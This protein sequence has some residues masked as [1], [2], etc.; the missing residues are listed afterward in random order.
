MAAHLSRLLV[1][2]SLRPVALRA[3]SRCFSTDTAEQTFYQ[4]FDVEREPRPTAEAPELPPFIHHEYKA[5]QQGDGF[6]IRLYMAGVRKESVKIW[7]Q[8][9]ELIAEGKRDK[10][11]EDEDDTGGLIKYRMLCPPVQAFDLDSIK[12]DL[13]N[14]ILKV[15][16]PKRD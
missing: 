2:S 12:A 10:E 14:G 1:S 6:H 4:M 7:V 15:F 3:G 8:H 11:F 9:D 5:Q 13:M 16:V